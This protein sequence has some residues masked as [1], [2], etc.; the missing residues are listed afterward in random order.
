MPNIPIILI[1]PIIRI[2][3]IFGNIGSLIAHPIEVNKILRQQGK[4]FLQEYN[5][6]GNSLLLRGYSK[7]IIK[8]TIGSS[9]FYPIFDFVYKKIDNKITAGLITAII[10]TSILDPIDFLKVR[11]ISGVQIYVSNTYDAFNKFNLI[12]YVK[13]Y[14]TGY[15]FNLFRI[16]LYFTITMF[17]VKILEENN[18]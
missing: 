13:F 10:S 3:G 14:Y 12:Q 9:I 1:I 18:F 4:T 7:G 11:H 2:I 5:K 15:F 17:I 6:F 16:V 8:T